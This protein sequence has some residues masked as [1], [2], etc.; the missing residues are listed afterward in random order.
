M[1]SIRPF[2]S[3]LLFRRFLLPALTAGLVLS[4]IAG[5]ERTAS[6][7]VVYVAP[8][9]PRAEVVRF[10]P[11]PHHFWIPG[12]WGYQPGYGHLWYG[13]RWEVQRPGYTRSQP[14][15]VAAGRGRGWEFRRGGW[16][17][18]SGNLRGGGAQHGANAPRGGFHAGGGGRGGHR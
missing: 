11:S 15:W 18:G 14:G 9:A 16:L 12:Y 3:P 17:R 7:Q 6:A 2:V 1:R 10:P 13:G 8:P 4:G 5:G